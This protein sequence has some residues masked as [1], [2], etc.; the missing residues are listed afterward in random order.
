MPG[1]LDLYGLILEAGLLDKPELDKA[2]RVSIQ[3]HRSLYDVILDDTL[4]P[5]DR[6]LT[7][8]GDLLG[9]PYDT[10]DRSTVDSGVAALIP[11]SVAR[12]YHVLPLFQLG[13]ELTV[14]ISNP[15]D[16]HSLD[17]IAQITGCLINPVLTR[18]ENI[19][20]LFNY[21][22]RVDDPSK[23]GQLSQLS[24]LV[25]MG[26]ELV[27]GVEA[28]ESS[29]EDL[30]QE[31]PIAKIV[32]SI[33]RQA[34]ELGASDIHIEPEE[35]VLKIRFRVDGILRDIMMPPK[36]LE[37]AIIS[38]LKI[39]ANIDITETRKPQDGRISLMIQEREIDFRVSTVRTIYGEKMV[40]RI[41]D[42]AGNFFSIERLGLTGKNY[43]VFRQLI[44]SSSGV[45]IVC[46][47][48]GSGKT[49]S[50]YSALADINTPEKN[51][52]TIE[53]P[54]EYSLPGVNQ[55]P[56][57][58]KLG[59]DFAKGLAT[60]VRQDPDIIMVG[61]GRDAET[62]SI[63]IQAA[64]TGHL[65]FTTLH[66]RNAP[67]AITRLLD[68]G[69]APY[70]LTSAIIGVIGQRLVRQLCSH[71]KQEQTTFEPGYRYQSLRDTYRDKQG[72]SL[73]IF[74]PVGCKYC[75]QQGYQGRTGI[76][77]IMVMTPELQALTNQRA[78]AQALFALAC[79]QGMVS[80]LDN[81]L[82]K[83]HQGLTS[84]DELARVLDL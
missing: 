70:L 80:L 68:M 39:L 59:V 60:I 33:I 36:E 56:I 10:I 32:D 34:V 84:L 81:G 58:P 22:Y 2:V 78:T 16:T 51:I 74:E 31:A 18:R 28:G 30:A 7:T 5:E 67:G 62:A 11:E 19:T 42:K 21:C 77:E 6:F 4:I 13:S 48:T 14:A 53:D 20:N 76:F 43:T 75:E 47:P 69:L 54:V 71:C 29:I 46:G 55:I 27:G 49:S 63:A 44:Q 73:R 15:F 52:I 8:L 35:N 64:L 3:Q 65:V 26:L 41:L 61:E 40:L 83:V 37:S 12:H 25:E 1:T 24:T 23:M 38:R 79:E 50:L 82:E 66:T 45:I 17:D 57:N 9:F 72:E